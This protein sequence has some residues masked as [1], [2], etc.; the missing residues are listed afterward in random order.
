MGYEEKRLFPRVS[1]RMPLRL[2]VR[3]KSEFYHALSSDI[4]RGG[5][6]FVNES[7]LSLHTVVD[8]QINMLSRIINPVGQVAWASA[9]PHSHRYRLGVQFQGLERQHVEFLRDFIDLKKDYLR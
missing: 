6:S 4:S 5:V 2:N 9:M 3:G 8:L 1:L 7:F